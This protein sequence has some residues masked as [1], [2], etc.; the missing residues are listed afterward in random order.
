MRRHSS[1][2]PCPTNARTHLADAC[3]RKIQRSRVKNAVIMYP[4]NTLSF[5]VARIAR[6]LG[7]AQ[8]MAKHDGVFVDMWD[9]LQSHQFVDIMKVLYARER[10][11][12][13]GGE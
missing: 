10:D 8:V 6:A 7:D 9:V 5:D 11:E 3:T 12:G 2:P 1:D 13:E 4:C